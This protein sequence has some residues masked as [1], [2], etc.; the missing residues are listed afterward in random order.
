MAAGNSRDVDA[1]LTIL[2]ELDAETPD[3]APEYDEWGGDTEDA[4]K[5]GL[6]AGAY[7]VVSRFRPA[8][9]ALSES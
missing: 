7:E 2:R 9:R 1:L 3:E 8:L 5:W 4:E 6:S